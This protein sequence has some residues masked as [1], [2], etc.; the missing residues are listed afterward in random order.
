MVST[1]EV[2]DKALI[3]NLRYALVAANDSGTRY[4][5]LY[6]HA[7]ALAGKSESKR[8][9]HL[10]SQAHAVYVIDRDRVA[11]AREAMERRGLRLAVD[12]PARV[13]PTPRASDAALKDSQAKQRS[14]VGMRN[15]ERSEIRGPEPIQ[16]WPKHIRDAHPQRI[17][18]AVTA[19]R[20]GWQPVNEYALQDIAPDGSVFEAADRF[21]IAGERTNKQAHTVRMVTGYPL[22]RFVG[23]VGYVDI[24]G[25]TQSVSERKRREAGIH[26]AKC[27]KHGVLL[28]RHRTSGRFTYCG[29]C[30]PTWTWTQAKI[31]R[32]GAGGAGRDGRER[33]RFG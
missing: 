15:A 21:T 3:A 16:Q 1:T 26:K 14:Q 30:G 8:L 31:D 27:P 19:A 33:S 9:R 28:E 11:V 7:V 23:C 12:S 20:I 18:G 24:E 29:P 32:Y 22:V 6:A 17:L 4:M 5:K 13:T 10:A 25:N 2:S